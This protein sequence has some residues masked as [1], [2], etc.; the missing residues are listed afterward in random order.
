MAKNDFP[1]SADDI[2]KGISEF[3][4]FLIS[5]I[6]NQFLSCEPLRILDQ[7]FSNIFEK[8]YRP[9]YRSKICHNRYLII[10][11][12]TYRD[13]CM[14]HDTFTLRLRIFLLGRNG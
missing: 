11:T 2:S 7:N 6:R 3:L 14:H 9:G 13:R 8:N 12:V 5:S 10:E 1:K 4:E